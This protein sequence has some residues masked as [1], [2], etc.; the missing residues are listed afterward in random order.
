M[1]YLFLA[2]A[3]LAGVTK[4]YCGKMVSS[5]V[6]KT[7]DAMLANLLRMLLCIFIGFG[8]VV[9]VDGFI[10][11]NISLPSLLISFLSGISNA[12]FVISWLFAVTRGAY[13]LVDVFLTIGLAV[14][15]ALCSI[16]FDEKIRYNHIIGF[17]VLIAAVLLMCSYNNSV[18]TKLTVRS[19][20]LLLLCGLSSGL[21]SFSQKWFVYESDGASI[22]AFNFYTYVFAA[23]VLFFSF[24]ILKSGKK[25]EGA[26]EKFTL[27]PVWHYIVI[28]AVM[29]FS[30]SFFM[31]LAATKL[32][33][34]LLYPLS[35][36]L[37]LLL[38]TVMCAV[39]FK[40]KPNFKSILGIVLAFVAIM[41]INLL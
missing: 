35:N 22:S 39:F 1:G 41:L 19:L 27:R 10:G 12:I 21:A 11:F 16:F 7:A 34:V 33:A 15:I 9:F 24:F 13:M 20:L 32:D 4:G 30:N 31:T 37:A 36:G 17:A 28:M 29:L 40:E 5:S 23:A 38:S 2:L 6:K 25:E 14:P 3:N 8:V 18:K 26:V